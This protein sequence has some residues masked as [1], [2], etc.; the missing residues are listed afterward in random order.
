MDKRAWLV[1]LAVAWG[2]GV[3]AGKGLYVSEDFGGSWRALETGIPGTD[4]VMFLE[5]RGE[6][7]LAGTEGSG[8]F[9]SD[10]N[11]QRW[12]SIGSGLPGRKITA[13]HA[14]GEEIYAGVFGKGLFSMRDEGATWK[15]ENGGLGNL[16]VRAVMKWNGALLAATDGG[17]FRRGTD[18][19][20]WTQVFAESQVVSLNRAEGT[21]VAGGVLG[22]LQ[23]AD[24]VRW[25]WISRHGAAHN[26]AVLDARI[27]L[28]NIS[29][30]L[31]VSE[32]AGKDWLLAE[33]GPKSGS[34]V[35]E[36]VKAG[37][38]LV[39]SNNY[40]IHRSKD[41]GR[42]WQ[43]VYRTEEMAFL[44]LATIGTTIYGG[45]GRWNERRGKSE[46]FGRVLELEELAGKE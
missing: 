12:R 26:S 41:G 17:I 38:Y 33:Y 21:L 36:T 6:Q 4:T 35:Y 23:S 24:G 46:D 15:P 27:V 14:A 2:M 25:N 13:L 44:D 40:G 32:N 9:L 42:T 34:Y 31:L 7:V 45:T 39:L 30:D 3:S 16:S 10:T 43:C 22:A 19:G 37:D 29:G 18:G 11:R 8:L 5:R 20:A 28:M 1:G